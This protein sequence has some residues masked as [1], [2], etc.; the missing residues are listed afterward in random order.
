[1]PGIVAHVV[2]SCLSP[3]STQNFE[4]VA[5]S[6]ARERQKIE[7]GFASSEGLTP[8]TDRVI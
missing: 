2:V 8:S 3:R 1:V 4:H 7:G 6:L 5:A